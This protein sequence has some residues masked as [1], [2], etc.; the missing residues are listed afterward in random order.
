[1]IYRLLILEIGD[2]EVFC[3]FG[4]NYKEGFD[5]IF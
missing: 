1:M 2:E 4:L 5:G 3:K